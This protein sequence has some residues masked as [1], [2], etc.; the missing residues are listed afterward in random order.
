MYRMRKGFDASFLVG[1]Q[2]LQVAIGVS[3]VIFNFD[4]GFRVLAT[5]DFDVHFDGTSKSWSCGNPDS[6][7]CVLSLIGQTVSAVQVINEALLR[8]AFSTGPSVDLKDDSDEFES[9]TISSPG[10]VLVV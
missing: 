6:A 7:A 9:F 2:L 1:Q 4:Q 8:I 3:D 10:A 5:T